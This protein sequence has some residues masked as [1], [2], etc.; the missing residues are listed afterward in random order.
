MSSHRLALVVL[1]GLLIANLTRAGTPAPAPDAHVLSFVPAGPEATPRDLRNGIRVTF[2]RDMVPP[3]TVGK[4]TVDPAFAIKPAL[5][6]D[7]RWVDQRTLAFFPKAKDGLQPSTTYEVRLS[8]KAVAKLGK[9]LD[10][11]PGLR[12][13][14]DRIRVSHLAFDGKDHVERSDKFQSVRPIVHV[15]MSQACSGFALAESCRFCPADAFTTR[16]CT[17]AVAAPM[18]DDAARPNT[19]F[20]LTPASPLSPKSSYVFK[21]GTGLRPA[22]GD[23]GLRAGYEHAFS[24]Y[25]PA[26]VAKVEP[27]G[28]D[29]AADH[30][31][32]SIG[33]TTPVAPERVR[34]HLELVEKGKG[35]QAIELGGDWE[36]TSYSWSGDLTIDADYQIRIKPGLDDVFGQ[37]LPQGVIGSFHVGDQSPRLRMERGIFVVERSTG[38]YSIWAR[39]LDSFRVRCAEVPASR[40]TP[41]LTGP[42]NYDAWWDAS[43]SGNAA[44][45]QALRLRPR[46]KSIHVRGARNQWHDTSLDLAAVCGRS[47]KTGVYMLE[48]SAEGKT[49]EADPQTRHAL[50]SLTDLGLLA[51]VG[52]ASSLVWV[53][54]LASGQPVPDAKVRIRD[55]AGKVRFE[56]ITNQDGV[57]QGPGA[58][59]LA[60]V[61]PRPA[62]AQEGDESEG[63]WEEY[64][65]RRVIITAQTADDFAVLDTNWNNG[66]QIWNFA[67][68]QDRG[69][70]KVRVR[71]FLHSDRGLYRPGDTVHLKGLVRL[72]ETSGRMAVP[73]RKRRVH[74]TITDPRDKTMLDENL[75]ISAFGGFHED[76]P[77]ASE[78]ALGDY[79]VRAEIEG[80]SFVDHFS[81]EEYRPRTFEVKVRTARPNVLLG[82]ALRFEVSANFL[83]GSPLGGGKLTYSL[84]RRQHLPELR[85]FDEYVFQDYASQHDLGRYWARYEE[86]SFSDLVADGEL[87]LDAKGAVRVTVKDKDKL[88]VPQEYILQATVTDATGESV[89]A[90]QMVVGHK[91]DLYLGLHPSEFV[92][93]V[94][95]PFGIQVVGFDKEGNRRAA[96]AGLE[97]TQRSY[98]CGPH[99]REGYWSCEVKPPK[100]PAVKRIVSVPASGSAAVERVVLKEPGEYVVRVSADGKGEQAV[101]SEII[102]VIGKGEAFWSG[103]EGDRMTVIASKAKY[104][105]GDTA[106]L[107][108]QARMPGAL[109]LTTLE[110]DG[111]MAYSLTNLATSGQAIAVKVKEEFA[112]NVFASVVMVRGRTGEGDRHRPRFKMG[113]V[114][115][116]V[117][118]SAQRLHVTVT[119]ERPSYQPGEEVKA[120]V[121]VTSAGGEPVR[122][123]LAL[124][125]AD[126][127]VLQIVGFKTP[128]PMAAFYMPFGLGVESATTWNRIL[129]KIDP[130]QDDDEEGGDGGGDEAGR[131]RSRFMATAFWAPALVTDGDGRV[132][133]KFKAPDN[134]TA[135]RLMAV[136]AD[137][138]ARFGSGEQRFTVAKPLQA[139]PALPRFLSPGDHAQAAVAIHNNTGDKLDVTVTA[140]I[141]GLRVQGGRVRK[142]A[143]PAHAYRRLVFAVK[144]ERDGEAKF[145]FK[146]EAQDLKDA[147]LV[148]VPVRRASIPET[149]VVGEGSTETDV[150]H[151]LP[152]LGEVVPGRGGLEISLDR[153]G[154]GRLD[155]GLAYLVG[156]PYGCLEQ[157]TS[158][159]VPMIALSQLARTAHLPGVD[160]GQAK[161]YVD[162]GIAKILR[163]QHDD[164][165]FGLWIGATPEA[166]Y[167]ATGLWGLSVAKAAGFK[168]DDEALQKGAAYLRRHA[169]PA[170]HGHGGELLGERGTEAFAAYV[171]ATLRHGDPGAL[172]RLFEERGSLPIYGRAFLLRALL[173]AGRDDLAK[174]LGD[175]LFA[176]VP[177]QGL[178]AEVK[179]ELGWYWSSDVRTTALALWAL[180][181]AAPRDPR[182]A[183]LASTLLES[184][185][186][187]RWGSTQENVFG[188]LALAELAKARA[189]AEP[190]TVSVRLGDKLVAKKT[191]AAEAVAHVSVPLPK[192]GKGPLVIAAEGGEIFYSARIR[193]ERPM[194][195]ESFDHGI[196]VE[197]SYLNPEDKTP[198]KQVQLGQQIL[199]RLKVT[200]PI[201][202]AHIAVVDRLPAGFEP[203]L[204]RFA[205]VD[206]WQERPARPRWWRDWGTSW[207]NEE[208][209]DD[210]M[211]IFAD[212][213]ATGTSQHEYLVRA[214]CTGKFVVPPA[215]AEAMYVPAVQGR[216]AAASLEIVK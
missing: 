118:A 48:A 47:A 207:Q 136:A 43:A 209:R 111:V 74:L 32:V 80:Q 18:Q 169:T 175:E 174:Q 28:D 211:Q 66:I 181:Q 163:H 115:L 5:A 31:R 11:W 30:V 52:N 37:P 3:A 13:V 128:D 143:I 216:S 99:G 199:V 60:N 57:V 69:G 114:D 61:K 67:V 185:V 189:S 179:G 116:K 9:H 23:A 148:K 210:R 135:F 200:S 21:C 192:L 17:R 51:K 56:G 157:T 50:A 131:I 167:T 46:E 183:Q 40:L 132:Q 49:A 39:N 177:K 194:A 196:I 72:L 58:T 112:P 105:P 96:S 146:A 35:T 160:A 54:S 87:E 73:S 7:S 197:R 121:R 29:V 168:V 65:A 187:G 149:L 100:G 191:V 204:R 59:V 27:S 34:A 133:V 188:L 166:H 214:A 95:M 170:G 12:F 123:E 107:V 139:I 103:D 152:L 81:V 126:E 154:M 14:Y 178:I 85:G 82:Q 137:R 164:G 212:T 16:Q 215:S 79:R 102:W 71:G 19:R 2:D 140:R 127:G 10:A 119:T 33:F 150:S 162:I 15:T 213:L 20:P 141:T 64:R 113:L 89:S 41:V 101:A 44:D 134:L 106:L 1:C 53:V 138:G 203:V 8:P 193:V 129:R 93:A 97:I 208:L 62:P 125:A 86:R 78:T 94:D 180:T 4:P 104:V 186:E 161:K 92:Q 184:R 55:L 63:E 109:A 38:R 195:A 171:L 130:N 83:Y 173:A 165:G 145:V 201:A 110:R 182:L 91:S 206:G 176:L 22:L 76:V 155:E 158:K 75:A 98:D 25:G 172:G 84:R 198:L 144:A 190:V 108:P 42:W 153:A 45:Y 202:R 26:Q 88:K 159:V 68:N 205:N 124:A 122:A 36:Q 120:S 77:I 156:Y 24:T 90:G 70:G 151:E 117:E 142:A 147:V 6:G